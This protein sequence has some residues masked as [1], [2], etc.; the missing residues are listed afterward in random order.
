[1]IPESYITEWS[2]KAPWGLNQQIE[3]DLIISCALVSIYSDEFLKDHLAFRGGTAI[4]KLYLTPQPRYSEDIDLV[5]VSAEP[6]TKFSQQT[7]EQ[8][9][10]I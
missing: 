3:Q 8:V 2:E 4:G 6:I 10:Y 9:R 1:M 7:L 5:Q